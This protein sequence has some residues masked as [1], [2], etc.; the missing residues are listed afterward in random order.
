MQIRLKLMGMLKAKTPAGGVLEVADGATIDH[1]LCVL[2]IA[3][4]TNQVLTV[5]GQFE[6]NRSRVLAANDELS[7]IPPVGGG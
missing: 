3:P 5:N 1:V 7:V 4:Q 2:E 6:R